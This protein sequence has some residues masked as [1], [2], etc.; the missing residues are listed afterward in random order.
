MG[1]SLRGILPLFSLGKQVTQPALCLR[2][3]DPKSF[4]VFKSRLDHRLTND[5]EVVQ[6]LAAC[7]PLDGFH[8]RDVVGP[9]FVGAFLAPH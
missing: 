5:H 1:D 4:S 2:Q 3:K 6:T 9:R 7:N 8:F